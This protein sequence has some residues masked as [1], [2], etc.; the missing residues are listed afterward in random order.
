MR[1][2]PNWERQISSA[3]LNSIKSHRLV[4]ASQTPSK[5]P[6]TSRGTPTTRGRSP[7]PLNLRR[8]PSAS[9]H[10]SPTRARSQSASQANLA[11]LKNLV[12]SG[13]I[14]SEYPHTWEDLT[15][16][17]FFGTGASLFHLPIPPLVSFPADSSNACGNQDGVC[18]L[19]S[20][21]TKFK[22]ALKRS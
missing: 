10:R 17:G 4:S 12:A 2:P 15:N 19:L 7:A 3:N 11:S 22:L 16:F 21:I 18:L 5:D 14:D 8:T 6:P 13:G 9:P 20:D 1:S